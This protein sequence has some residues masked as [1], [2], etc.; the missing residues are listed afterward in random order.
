[1]EPDIRGRVSDIQRCCVSDGPGIRT[2]VFLQGCPLHC[3][4]CHNPEFR[5][6]RPLHSF[7][8]EACIN[9]GR[10]RNPVGGFH[11]VRS[12]E[13]VCNGCGRCERECPA[14]AQTVR[15]K[16]VP[17]PEVMRIIRRDVFYFQQTGGGIT[18]S[19][20]EPLL[21][22]VFAE[23]LLRAARE[24][25][26][27]TAV[28][29]SGAVPAGTLPAIIRCCDL[30]LFDIKTIPE[31]YSDLIGIEWEQI[32]ANLRLLSDAGARIRL[33][34]PV[35]KGWNDDP[36]LPELLRDLSRLPGVEETEL[37][38]YHPLGRGKAAAAGLPE[39]EWEKMGVPTETQLEQWRS[40]LRS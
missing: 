34:T 7:R 23:A 15:G 35:V 19:G 9:C 21:Q 31:R 36:A 13:T 26:I 11:C 27:S 18:L 40:I 6:A 20:G 32:Y 8:S 33:R 28:E 17:V 1:M 5:P 22:E 12:P 16:S 39:P 24:E 14:G 30:F 10:C 25:G 3:P 37:L 29:T 38:P 4:W 2:T